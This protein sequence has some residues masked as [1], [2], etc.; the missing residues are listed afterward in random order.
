MSKFED[1]PTPD[2]MMELA[3]PQKV[4]DRGGDFT[5]VAFSPENPFTFFWATGKTYEASGRVAWELLRDFYK[6]AAT[7]SEFDKLMKQTQSYTWDKRV[8]PFKQRK[9]WFGI[10]GPALGNGR[11]RPERTTL[12]ELLPA[13]TIED[14]VPIMNRIQQGEI[15][16]VSAQDEILSIVD[17]YRKILESIQID[18]SRLAFKLAY[19]AKKPG[20]G[21]LGRV[22]LKELG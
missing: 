14:L 9:K 18:V 16:E 12:S 19:F 22:T 6:E 13:R 20:G 2:E 10:F 5:T 15:D 4:V 3:P 1:Y 17:P 7:P 8:G 11:W 21:P